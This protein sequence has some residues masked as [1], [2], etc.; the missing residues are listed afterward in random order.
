[1]TDL[2]GVAVFLD[3]DGTITVRDTSEH[4]LERL[5]AGDWRLPGDRYR[6][7]ELTGR[8]CLEEEWAM[9]PHDADL[10]LATAREVPLDPG[11]A[12]L[13]AE[14][15]AAGATV[16]V[17]SD[18]YGI[19][20]HEE[21]APLGLTALT[22]RVRDGELSFPHSAADCPCAS[23]GTCKVLPI[24][25]AKR[26]G[27]PTVMVGDGTSDRRAALVADRVLAKNGLADWCAD[28][29]VAHTPFDNLT[30]VR[31]ILLAPTPVPPATESRD[32]S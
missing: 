31:R 23:C 5:A 28:E 25:R 22:A 17:V 8:Q 9:L 13:T 18:G 1:M 30:D 2:G 16:T 32:G 26:Q 29:G 24:L 3:F 19:R 10:L 27:R 20:V 6:R 12:S 14:L 7:G 11:F 15:R 4:L 21:C